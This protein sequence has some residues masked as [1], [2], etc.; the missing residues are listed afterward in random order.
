MIYG[1][2]PPARI[3]GRPGAQHECVNAR[4]SSIPNI[5]Q[6]PVGR[7]LASLLLLHGL[8]VDK[9]ADRGELQS[10]IANIAIERHLVATGAPLAFARYEVGK[11]RSVATLAAIHEFRRIAAKA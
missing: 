5:L 6:E 1:Q 7:D 4:P 2:R 9:A 10:L 11:I 3:R 8:L